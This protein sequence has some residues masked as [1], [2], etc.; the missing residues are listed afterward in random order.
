MECVRQ[1]STIGETPTV[2][3]DERDLLPADKV[4]ELAEE[5]VGARDDRLCPAGH[6][7]QAKASSKK[8]GSHEFA[9]EGN[10]HHIIGGG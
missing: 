8:E 2:V 7:A 5:P 3:R 1:V 4:R 9:G 6:G 10:V